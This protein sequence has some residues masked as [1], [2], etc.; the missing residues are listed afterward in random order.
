[1]STVE[2]RTPDMTVT[3]STSN[4]AKFTNNNKMAVNRRPK[5]RFQIHGH[6]FFFLFDEQ[7]HYNDI[8]IFIIQSI[9]LISINQRP[10]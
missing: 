1:M 6:Y 2:I 3:R 7:H 4:N 8:I 5:T 9:Y 10:S